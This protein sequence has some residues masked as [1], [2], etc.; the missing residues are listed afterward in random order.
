MDDG[1]KGLIHQ[2]SSWFLCCEL[3]TQTA[4]KGSLTANRR[5]SYLLNS[6]EEIRYKAT[7]PRAMSKQ[8]RLSTPSFVDIVC[9]LLVEVIHCSKN[10][11]NFYLVL[12]FCLLEQKKCFV[13]YSNIYC[14]N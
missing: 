7:Y 10:D 12:S 11:P 6:V 2:R 4:Y 1:E 14:A 9:H 5:K 8:K 13:L 3:Y